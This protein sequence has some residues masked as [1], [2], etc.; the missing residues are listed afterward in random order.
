MAR[1][2]INIGDA[3]NDGEG[4]TLRVAFDKINDNFIE[5]YDDIPTDINELDDANNLLFDGDYYSLENAPNA[6]TIA[7]WNEAYGWGDHRDGGYYNANT[8]IIEADEIITSN[9]RVPAGE[10]LR[11]TV[12][13][14]GNTAVNHFEMTLDDSD[15]PITL[16]Q[17]DM[18]I[19]NSSTLKFQSG[20]TIDFSGASV[21]NLLSGNVGYSANTDSWSGDAPETLEDAVNRLAVLVRTLNGG[22]GA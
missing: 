15:D 8:T 7:E 9:F 5:V 1:Q 11:I 22:T 19:S 16:V 18:Q 4:D 21:A 2:F 3:A 17:T 20:G 14:E 12:N 6:N 13:E 10:S